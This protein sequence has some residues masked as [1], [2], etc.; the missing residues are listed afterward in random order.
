MP[1]SIFNGLTLRI[2]FLA[3]VMGLALN[4]VRIHQPTLKAA[5]LPTSAS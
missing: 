3:A 2:I 4:A 5:P 1:P